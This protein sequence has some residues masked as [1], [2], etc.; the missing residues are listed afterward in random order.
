MNG[1]KRRAANLD[2][3]QD[4]G[5]YLPDM[6]TDDFPQFT[7]AS[8]ELLVPPSVLEMFI[9]MAVDAVSTKRYGSRWRYVT[10]LLIAHHCT[11]YL[12]TYA[13][14]S[15][16]AQAAAQGGTVTG[17]LSSASLG[18]ARVTYDTSLVTKGAEAFGDLNMTEYGRQFVSFAK[19]SF[20]GG[21]YIV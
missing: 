6:F 3:A 20:I 14:S 1:I 15:A 9:E 13:E 18:D 7:S 10:G 5:T 8:K 16:S 4:K 17:V 21:S 2:S 12:R 19:A 11:R